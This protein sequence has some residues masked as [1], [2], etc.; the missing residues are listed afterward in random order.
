MNDKEYV[1]KVCSKC[2]NKLNDK[3]LCNIRQTINGDYKCCN[4]KI[5]K[6]K[7]TKQI[8]ENQKEVDYLRKIAAEKSRVNKQLE[9]DIRKIIRS[10]ESLSNYELWVNEKCNIMIN[11]N[12]IIETIVKDFEKE[13]IEHLPYKSDNLVYV[14]VKKL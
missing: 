4:E 10:G 1:D 2:E 3:D 6:K 14:L 11:T 7:T 8:K 13:K 12:Y 5:T 9:E